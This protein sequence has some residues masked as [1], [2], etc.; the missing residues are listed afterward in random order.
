M[1]IRFLPKQKRVW[2]ILS[3]SIPNFYYMWTSKSEI[4]YRR[5]HSF[6][7]KILKNNPRINF[8][9]LKIFKILIIYQIC[10]NIFEIKSSWET[11]AICFTS[12]ENEQL[13]ISQIRVLQSHK[14]TIACSPR[15]KHVIYLN[16]SSDKCTF[17]ICFE[18]GKCCE[19]SHFSVSKETV[20]VQISLD[21]LE[22]KTLFHFLNIND[23]YSFSEW[24]FRILYYNDNLNFT[25][26]ILGRVHDADSNI[27]HILPSVELLY[28]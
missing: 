1:Y 13:P 25:F 23:L 27:I 11:I 18:M 28:E 19:I 14:F 9:P 8:Y 22:R 26:K 6:K 20:K 12:G 3:R 4:N 2:Y 10:D 17:N 5:R 7:S 24:E 16:M 15:V 21:V